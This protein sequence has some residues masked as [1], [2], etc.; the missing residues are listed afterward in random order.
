MA[1]FFF[2]QRLSWSPCI[3]PKHTFHCIRWK[4][5]KPPLSFSTHSTAT[6]KRMLKRKVFVVPIHL[7]R[8]STL[9]ALHSNLIFYWRTPP[10]PLHTQTNTPFRGTTGREL[11]CLASRSEKVAIH[12][13]LCRILFFDIEWLLYR[14]Q[15]RGMGCVVFDVLAGS[16]DWR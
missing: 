6:V 15:L 13:R 11:R 12:A 14:P 3:S 2:L 9:Q 1:F 8:N 10:P 16:R 5:W 4:T 7:C